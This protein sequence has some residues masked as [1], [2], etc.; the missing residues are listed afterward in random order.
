MK[1]E[2]IF[3]IFAIVWT[4]VAICGTVAN[5]NA[6]EKQCEIVLNESMAMSDWKPGAMKERTAWRF[7]EEEAELLA[8][9]MTSEAAGEG[10]Q[11]MAYVLMVVLNR[12]RSDQF[13]NT[14][15]EV[16][17]QKRPD[18][19]HQFCPIDV[20]T[21]WTMEPSDIAYEII[22][23]IQAEYFDDAMGALFFCETTHDSWHETKEYL[24]TY[25]N[26]KFYK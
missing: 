24:F 11:G 14:V 6:K 20:G 5:A 22:A 16:I 26:H 3:K 4:V 1:K 13:P 7:T 10:D 17:F 12:V 8:R 19:L 2:T 23:D 21:F 15:K 25:K 9:L 18:G